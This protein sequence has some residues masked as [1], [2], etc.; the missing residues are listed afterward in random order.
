MTT[1]VFL[2]GPLSEIAASP[3]IVGAGSVG[4][5]AVLK[6]HALCV[7]G[8]DVMPCLLSSPGATVSGVLVFPDH[9][10]LLKLERFHNLFGA[11][12]GQIVLQTQGR[13][14]L[15]QSF[16][17]PSD[18]APH[19]V[20]AVPVWTPEQ[21]QIMG[22]A[23]LEVLHLVA[24]YSLDALKARWPMA[25]AHAASRRRACA[26]P[27][28]AQQRNAW[29][30]QDVALAQG[31]R[32]YAW[33]FAVAEDDLRFR[34]FDGA[35]S[36]EVKRAGFVMCDAVTVLPYDPTRDVVMV[37]EQ[38]RYG[39]W[40]RGARNPWLLEPVAGRVDPFESPEDCALRETQE[41]AQITLQK[42]CLLPVGHVYPSP[43]AITEFLYQYV[44]L[45][46]L[47]AGSE[48]VS[49]LDSE[50][51]NIRSHIISFDELMNLIQSGE[52]TNGPLV[53]SAY[54]LAI[55]RER[56]RATQGRG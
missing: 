29:T 15:V 41:E 12:A 42:G 11:E 19:G 31:K 5:N 52:V 56:L 34:K 51:E 18:R 32:P 24:N 28:P 20:E 25:L 9:D 17:L 35:F 47:P 26:E 1:P 30:P 8:P 40:L 2:Y 39:P 53:Q 3:E 45:A 38:F 46:D 21:R 13:E 16:F 6:D 49:G 27:A 37:I 23:S 36:A 14:S 10:S 7:S 33:Y 4:Q 43:G 54:W 48:G 50:A 22:M 55:N 44:A